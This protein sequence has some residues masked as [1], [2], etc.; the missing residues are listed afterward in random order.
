MREDFDKNTSDKE[1][2]REFTSGSL[3]FYNDEISR[4]AVGKLLEEIDDEED[5]S[6]EEDIEK[7]Y[8][9]EKPRG[10]EPKRP[11]NNHF[12]D[13][14]K[15]GVKKTI[16]NHF[17]DEERAEN[18][19]G[20]GFVRGF[21]RGAD[22]EERA[23]REIRQNNNFAEEHY[24]EPKRPLSS[25][26]SSRNNEERQV[27]PVS[28]EEFSEAREERR[29]A[30]REERENYRRQFLDETKSEREFKK[31]IPEKQQR[32]S[33]SRQQSTEKQRLSEARPQS[34][35]KRVEREREELNNAEKRYSTRPLE[36]L[37]P[38]IQKAKQGQSPNR[39]PSPNNQVQGVANKRTNESL[40]NIDAKVELLKLPIF[41]IMSGALVVMLALVVVLAVQTR[42]LSSQVSE[43]SEFEDANIT[44]RGI[45]NSQ[46]EDIDRFTA[47]ISELTDEVNTL[48]LQ[49]QQVNTTNIPEDGTEDETGTD[50]IQTVGTTHTV[51]S[52][53]TLNGLGY[54]FFGAA[55]AG[56]QIIRE[57]NNLTSDNLTID[58]VLIIPPRD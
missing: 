8:I 47:R 57:A 25:R 46:E 5:I 32:G 53:D 10:F 2:S 48:T 50:V 36:D 58:Q 15:A 30:F 52:G 21:S 9:N 39:R 31:V 45:L 24:E 14:E 6:L 16:N 37:E 13:E 29:N 26:G 44:L 51:V 55:N 54:R 41:K 12:Y 18:D 4:K 27:P 35:R 34:N 33:D 7:T 1:N 20:G 22:L 17:Y 23:R 40:N 42:R 56:A 19:E 49:L 38:K 43:L 28:R 11:I 3:D